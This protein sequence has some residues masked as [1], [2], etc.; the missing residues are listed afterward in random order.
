MEKERSL[1]LS[2]RNEKKNVTTS[3]C[4]LAVTFD[5]CLVTVPWQPKLMTLC[6]LSTQ[7][8]H[9]HVLSAQGKHNSFSLQSTELV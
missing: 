7:D 1:A 3:T 5:Y 8:I 4:E 9:Q 6:F 2:K